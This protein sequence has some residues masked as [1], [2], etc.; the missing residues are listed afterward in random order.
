MYQSEVGC[1]FVVNVCLSSK[2]RNGF[3]LVGMIVISPLL[4]DEAI[5]LTLKATMGKPGITVL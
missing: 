5:T 2:S 4:H 1:V 3:A